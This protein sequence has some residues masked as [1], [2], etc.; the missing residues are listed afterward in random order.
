MTQF[1]RDTSTLLI[2]NFW[3][4]SSALYRESACHG[5]VMSRF[6]GVAVVLL[7]HTSNR[8][9]LLAT[10]P[11][12][13]ESCE[14]VLMW[15]TSQTRVCNVL[16]GRNLRDATPSRPINALKNTFG[17]CKAISRRFKCYA[18]S[19]CVP[20]MAR[21]HQALACCRGFDTPQVLDTYYLRPTHSQMEVVR[22]Y[23]CA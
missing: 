10:H 1:F 22:C 4:F 17:G 16:F 14:V 5:S 3:D 20:C 21:Y 2:N 19:V 15:V 6:F 12:S 18:Q 13:D 11:Q 9:I 23:V 7:R 8:H